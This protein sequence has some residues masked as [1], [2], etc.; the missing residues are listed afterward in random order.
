MHLV[1]SQS[2]FSPAIATV[3]R[4]VASRPTHPI[5][6]N[7][8]LVA[9]EDNQTLTLTGFD[10]SI[11][12]VMPLPAQIITGGAITLPSKLLGDIVS[13]LPDEDITLFNTAALEETA[14]LVTLTCGSGKYQINSLPVT[15]FPEL[16]EIDSSES[17]YIDV[18]TLRNGLLATM[19]AVSA[20]ETKRILTGISVTSRED[21]LEFAATDGHRLSVLKNAVEDGQEFSAVIPTKALKVLDNLIGNQDL[22]ISLKIDEANTNAIFELANGILIT[23]LLD[24]TYPNYRQLLPKDTARKIT[25]ERK[26]FMAALERIA[27]LADQ[28]NNIVKITTDNPEQE[29]SLSVDSPD[30]ATGRETVSVQMSGDDLEIAFNV[31]Y[32]SDGLKTMHTDEVQFQ[33][34]A[35]N[36]PALIVPI[37]GDEQTYLLMPVQIRA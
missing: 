11:A 35:A 5:L 30:V 9:D 3:S 15:E 27:V 23:R 20:D 19:I 26:L 10:L 7:I 34:N 22:P 29:I 4:A 8:K 6:G 1:I 17:F 13:R 36:Q 24:G 2:L 21:S 28:K 12:I 14:N 18:A 32:L 16:P 31:K 37:G 25:V 33:F